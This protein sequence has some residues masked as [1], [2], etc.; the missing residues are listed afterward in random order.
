MKKLY[1]EFKRETRE[2]KTPREIADIVPESLPPRE[3]IEALPETAEVAAA[4][5]GEALEEIGLPAVH[6]ALSARVA[7]WLGTA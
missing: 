2:L 1:R 3:L 4:F 6:E 7:D 5:L